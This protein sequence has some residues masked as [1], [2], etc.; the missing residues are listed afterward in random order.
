ME[1]TYR[2]GGSE[3]GLSVEVGLDGSDDNG[4]GVRGAGTADRV[5]TTNRIAERTGEGRAVG[6]GTHEDRVVGDLFSDVVQEGIG[7][8][9]CRIVKVAPQLAGFPSQARH[10]REYEVERG[11]G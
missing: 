1:E 2:L 11:H 10:L 5:G 7:K 3:D 4:T 6:G 8:G 9:S